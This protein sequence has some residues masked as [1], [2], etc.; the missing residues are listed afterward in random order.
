MCLNQT[1]SASPWR[2]E[3][4]AS[5]STQNE[6]KVLKCISIYFPVCIGSGGGG[7]SCLFFLVFLFSPLLSLFELPFFKYM[8]Q[9]RKNEMNQTKKE[10]E[11]AKR[12]L[13]ELIEKKKK[14][15][16]SMDGTTPSHYAKFCKSDSAGWMY[17][18]DERNMAPNRQ[19][20]KMWRLMGG[21]CFRVFPW[22]Y[23]PVALPTPT[24][25]TPHSQTLY[26]LLRRT[27]GSINCKLRSR[28]A[29]KATTRGLC[30]SVHY[31]CDSDG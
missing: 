1:A 25:C 14:K 31:P 7:L 26:L 12:L 13:L 6:N 4:N 20:G 17:F 2:L 3:M 22:L 19:R 16:M 11:K 24:V 23:L 9:G 28:K 29:T 21:V 27:R 18:E 30:M 5:D 15:R 10:K 8:N